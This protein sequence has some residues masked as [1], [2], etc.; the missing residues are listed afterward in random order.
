[1]FLYSSIH[2]NIFQEP[3]CTSYAVLGLRTYNELDKAP[4][5]RKLALWLGREPGAARV[6]RCKALLMKRSRAPSPECQTDVY[7]GFE[8]NL[9]DTGHETERRTKNKFPDPLREGGVPPGCLQMTALR[10]GRMA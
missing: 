8:A 10:K 2:S 4:A 1:M 5:S 6:K 9:D 7:R 3:D